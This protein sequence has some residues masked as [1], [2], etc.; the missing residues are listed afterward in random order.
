LGETNRRKTL[1]RHTSL[2]CPSDV[3]GPRGEVAG[4]RCCRGNKKSKVQTEKDKGK[5]EEF[6]TGKHKSQTRDAVG[7]KRERYAGRRHA[8]GPWEVLYLYEDQT[9]CE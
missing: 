1:S 8:L 2:F 3:A 9:S 7:K 6:T 5:G 4:A